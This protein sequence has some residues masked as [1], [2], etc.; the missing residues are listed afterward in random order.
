VFGSLDFGAPRWIIHDK[1]DKFSL[2]FRDIFSKLAGFGLFFII[3]M[4]DFWTQCWVIT[5][6][7]WRTATHYH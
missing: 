1:E 7:Q 5:C 4:L 3:E 6:M 2:D